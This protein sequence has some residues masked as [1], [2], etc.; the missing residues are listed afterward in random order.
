M[1]EKICYE[2]NQPPPDAD[3]R[4][5]LG[6]IGQDN[7]VHML[8]IISQ[9]RIR[10]FSGFI[11]YM[12]KDYIPKPT[13]SAFLT[14]PRRPSSSLPGTDS[15]IFHSPFPEHL[16]GSPSSD[17]DKND[18][19]VAIGGSPFTKVQVTGTPVPA[20]YSLDS[21]RSGSGNLNAPTRKRLSFSPHVKPIPKNTSKVSKQWQILSEL[22]FRRIFLVLNY[23]GRKSL[24]AVVS[25]EDAYK[26]LQMK[27]YPMEIFES[28]IWTMNG[29]FSFAGTELTDRR[30]Y[31]DWECGKTHHY[32][33]HV[34]RDGSLSFKGPYFETTNTLLHRT[35][36]CKRGHTYWTELLHYYKES[37]AWTRMNSSPNAH[38][39]PRDFPCE[40][41]ENELFKIFLNTKNQN[42]SMGVAA[43]SWMAFTDRFL[44]LDDNS[45]EK[46]NMK[47][48][49]LK[50]IDIYYDALDAPKTGNEVKVL[51]EYRADLFPHYMGKVKGYHSSSVLGKI[52][53]TVDT[54]KTERTSTEIRKLPLFELVQIPDAKLK[55]WKENYDNYRQ[56]MC[57]AL[58]SKNQSKMNP[59]EAVINKYKEILY[60]AADFEQRSRNMDDIHVDALAIYHV[61]YNFAK[62]KGDVRKCHFAWKLAGPALC[63]F[64]AVNSPERSVF[65][66]LPSVLGELLN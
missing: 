32:H 47:K 8:T 50:L 10:T 56:E 39:K 12:L 31:L 30:K 53:D 24:E 11:K 14:P 46:N 52:C 63:D 17:S 65:N 2:Q 29:R 58:S 33:C 62:I 23:I 1:I 6:S 40:E 7:S 13:T 28:E 3:A 20:Y 15:F 49:M 66:C 57:A 37:K 19:L 26:I 18:A 60:G 25:E 34:W 35:L 21:P 61:C 38:R 41:L 4:K 45:N 43:D 48:K 9:T 16:L 51:K 42:V 64:H 54:Y 44:T 36:G 59:A 5:I 27:G 22:E 55:F